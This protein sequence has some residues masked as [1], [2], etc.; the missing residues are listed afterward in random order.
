MWCC[1]CDKHTNV[2][3]NTH[4]KGLKGSFLKTLVLQNAG[5]PIVEYPAFWKRLLIGRELTAAA[6]LT[7][8]R[9]SANRQ[10]MPGFEVSPSGQ[11][12][13]SQ[14]ADIWRYRS[15]WSTR[16]RPSI[17]DQSTSVFRMLG[18]Q[19]L[20]TQHSAKLAFSESYLLSSTFYYKCCVEQKLKNP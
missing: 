14:K 9:A 18:T 17:L 10:L 6:T 12:W 3:L 15:Y 11:L 1:K 8:K 20:G 7:N 13:L 2:V 5:Y 19:L 4:K 16:R